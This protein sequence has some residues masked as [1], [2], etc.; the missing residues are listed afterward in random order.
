ML[1][2]K[3]FPINRDRI[4]RLSGKNL[5]EHYEYIGRLLYGKYNYLINRIVASEPP[6]MPE[7]WSATPGW[8]KYVN[9]QAEPIKYPDSQAYIFDMECMVKISHVPVMA[10]ALSDSHW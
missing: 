3:Q 1:P 7:I 8:T 10:I 6:P 2:A 5:S 9:K 4:P